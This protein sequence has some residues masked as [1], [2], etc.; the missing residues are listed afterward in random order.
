MTWRQAIGSWPPGG[1]PVPPAAC[2]GSMHSAATPSW[3][4]RKAGAL[5]GGV[6]FLAWWPQV[7]GVR[8]GGLALADLGLRVC[9][10]RKYFFP[11]R[12]ISPKA[13]TL[14]LRFKELTSELDLDPA[15]ALK[16]AQRLP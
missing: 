14:F 4:P 13:S 9:C 1:S 8:T 15:A 11:L 5:E 6:G 3:R 7:E 16:V 10:K 12:F 2:L